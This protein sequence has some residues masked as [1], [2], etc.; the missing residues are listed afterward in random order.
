MPRRIRLEFAPNT[1]GKACDI[2]G[3]VDDV[4]VHGWRQRPYGVNYAIW[5]HP[6]TPYYRQ[7]PSDPEWLPVH[8]QPD[9]IGYRH[10][11]GLLFDNE[12]GAPTRR[13]AP[14]VGIFRS[15]RLSQTAKG[16]RKV[17]WRLLAAGYDMDN[18][19]ARGFVE[20]E[21]PVIEPAD[22]E[23]AQE[24]VLLLRQ[25]IAG[26]AETASLLVRAVRRALF[27]EGAKVPL[28]AG[29]LTG[30]RE[31]FWQATETAFLQR[32]AEAADAAPDAEG[33]RDAWRRNLASTARALFA[34]TAPIDAT[35]A[36]RRPDRIAAAARGL[37]L[38]LAG[39]GKDGEALLQ[40]LGLPLPAKPARTAKPRSR[41][42]AA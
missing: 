15:N 18:M 8:A 26:A 33:I 36:D 27:S 19:K 25:L 22:P 41:R 13:P 11:V 29:L 38:A 40:R 31:R 28:D 10:W 23:R 17:Q 6:L 20:S 7:K 5:G 1:Q 37:S 42:S 3:I 16:E 9:G 4:V 2:L 30:V 14:A 35:G 21:L 39:I 24:F 12:E 32:A 34:E